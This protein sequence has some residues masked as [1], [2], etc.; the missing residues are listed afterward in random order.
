MEF[1]EYQQAALKT[2]QPAAAGTDPVAVPMLG[3]RGEAG[4]VATA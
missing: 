3:L 2:D 1:S 4:S